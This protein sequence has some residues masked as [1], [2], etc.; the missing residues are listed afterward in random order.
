MTLPEQKS[1]QMTSKELPSFKLVLVGDGGTGKTTL[2]QRHKTGNYEK[3]YIPT[4]GVSIHK[5]KFTFN[6]SQ[7][8][9]KWV[10]RKIQF[11]IWDTAGQERFKTIT[12]S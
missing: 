8:D 5:L 12:S 9:Q 4:V 10:P 7:W 11:E 6:S 1:T 3:K 2:V